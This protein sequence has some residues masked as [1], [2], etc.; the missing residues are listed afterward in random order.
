[1]EQ[2]TNL[3]H[4]HSLRLEHTHQLFTTTRM[5][6]SLKS[7]VTDI[8]YILKGNFPGANI[9]S[10]KHQFGQLEVT[11]KIPNGDEEVKARSERYNIPEYCKL[12]TLKV[13][14]TNNQLVIK[15]ELEEDKKAVY[16]E[17]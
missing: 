2:F 5:D 8:Q 10:I 9:L 3:Q 14:F 13:S 6:Y 7:E 17:F 11:Y 15:V 1:M 12:D 4:D 16:F